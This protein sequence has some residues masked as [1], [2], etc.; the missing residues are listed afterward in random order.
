M[1]EQETVSAFVAENGLAAPPAY[2]L[3]DLVSEV[4]ELATDAN[5]STGYGENPGAIEVGSDEIGDALFSLLALADSL[6]VDAGEAL[7][8]ALAKYEARLDADGTAG[9][10]E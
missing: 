7:S 2:R 6:G 1:D 3:L 9:S 8:E 10:G 4:G 5:E